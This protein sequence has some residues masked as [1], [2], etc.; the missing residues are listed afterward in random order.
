MWNFTPLSFYSEEN[1]PCDDR[2]F[3]VRPA[4]KASRGASAGHILMG[5]CPVDFYR[6]GHSQKTLFVRRLLAWFQAQLPSDDRIFGVRPAFNGS[7]DSRAGHILTGYKLIPPA[8]AS[9]PF[10]L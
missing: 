6:G 3:G 8:L 5:L 4:L 10:M 2:I 1:L 7:R 9:S